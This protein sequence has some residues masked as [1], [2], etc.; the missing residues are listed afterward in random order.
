[1]KIIIS[2]L[3]I[4]LLLTAGCA[5]QQYRVIN[6]ELHIYLK[7]SEAETVYILSSLDEYTPRPATDTGAGYWEAVLPSDMEFKYFFLVD[8]EAFVPECEM[9]E[10]DDFGTEN[11]VY[12]PLLGRK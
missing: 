5:V 2:F 9:K 4:L 6:Q 10:K 8:N 12:I 11:C 1:M 3:S 7:D